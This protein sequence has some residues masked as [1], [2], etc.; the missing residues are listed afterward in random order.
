[1][2]RVSF[3]VHAFDEADALRRLILSSLPLADLFDEWVVVDHR[4]TDHTPEVL[5]EMRGVL[6]GKGILLTTWREARDLSA[7]YTFADI[8]NDTIKACRSEIVVL[9][10]ADFILGPAFRGIL[11]RAVPALLDLR[12]RLHS[13]TFAVPVVWDRITTDAEGTVTDHGRVWVHPARPRVLL[14]DHVHYAQTGNGGRWEKLVADPQRPGRLD[15]TKRKEAEP[16]AVLSVNAKTPAKIALRDT[17]T[18]FM[19]DAHSGKATGEWLE[20]YR[21]GRTR[22]QGEYKYTPVNLRGWRLYAPGLEMRTA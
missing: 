14:R 20:N 17:M 2:R 15:L 1:V 10:D 5:A 6:A 7:S 22:S 12:Q 4:S 13:A 18:M 16:H 19:E 21:A 3:C 9:H 8:R 11:E